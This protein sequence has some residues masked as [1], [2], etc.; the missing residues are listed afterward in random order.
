MSD[1]DAP[2]SSSS[3]HAHPWLAHYDVE[4]PATLE[5]IPHALYDWLDEAARTVPRRPACRFVN[6]TISY[7]RLKDD[8]EAIAAGLRAA[9]GT[10]RNAM[11]SPASSVALAIHRHP[12]LPHRRVA[13]AK[14]RR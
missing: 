8:A 13:D 7:A 2:P 14:A 10:A 9:R 5:F 6:R 3:A 4:V 11:T 12:L 1:T